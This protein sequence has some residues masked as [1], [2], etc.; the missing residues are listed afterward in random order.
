MCVAMI[1][2]DK[3]RFYIRGVGPWD[4]TARDIVEVPTIAYGEISRMAYPER[5]VALPAE[6][7]EQERTTGD[8]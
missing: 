5:F 1:K 6:Y 7:V 4:N 8:Q 2:L 3:V